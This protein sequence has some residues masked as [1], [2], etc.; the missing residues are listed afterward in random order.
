MQ[1][2]SW[3]SRGLIYLKK[4]WIS[5]ANEFLGIPRITYLEKVL[6]VCGR[7]EAH[8]LKERP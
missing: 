1:T 4:L 7:R 8:L 5:Y 3:G 6:S 2:G